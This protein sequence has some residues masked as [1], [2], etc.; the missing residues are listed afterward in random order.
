MHLS[1]DKIAEI[2]VLTDEFYKE[3]DKIVSKHILDSKPKRK[4]RMSQS[5]VKTKV[6]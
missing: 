5:E 1:N 4:P 2:F 6:C 3:F